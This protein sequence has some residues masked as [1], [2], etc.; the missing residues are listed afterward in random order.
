MARNSRLINFFSLIQD[1]VQSIRWATDPTW[2]Q[3]ESP[4]YLIGGWIWHQFGG[5]YYDAS[6]EV[7]G[8]K[9][10][11]P[12]WGLP[13]LDDADWKAATVFTPN[14]RVTAERLPG[15]IVRPEAIKAVSTE[16]LTNGVVRVD[17]GKNFNG[18]TARSM[19][20]MP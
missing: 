18:W 19:R 10:G 9:D 16:M 14:M 8:M 3:H 4:S 13:D 5:D 11:L 1:G 2:K 15:N 12:E 17:M 20:T 6:K 7:Y